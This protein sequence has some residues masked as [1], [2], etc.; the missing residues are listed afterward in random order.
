MCHPKVLAIKILQNPQIRPVV[1]RDRSSLLGFPTSGHGER[2][3]YL[4]LS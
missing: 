3:G 1:A 2:Y 4:D